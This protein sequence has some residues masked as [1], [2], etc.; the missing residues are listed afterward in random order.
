MNAVKFVRS[1]RFRLALTYTVV[2]FAIAAMALGGVY[3][4]LSRSL[5]ARPVTSGTAF[6]TFVDPATGEVITIG[7][8][9]HLRL[10][11][12]E[13]LVDEQTLADLRSI[14][15]WILLGLFPVSLLVGWFVADRTLRP[16]GRVVDVAGEITRTED[17]SRRIAMEGPDDE[18]KELADTFDA[19]LDK[20]EDGVHAR[21]RILQDISHELRNPLAVMATTLDVALDDPDAS[22]EDLRATAEVVRRTVDRTAESV[23]DL[24]A[25]AR[26]EIP[27]SRRTEVELGQMVR[28]IVAEHR[29]ALAAVGVSVAF[30]IEEPVRAVV[31]EEAVRR[32]FGNLVGNAVRLTKPGSTIE[33]GAGRSGG[34][35]WLSVDDHGPGIDPRDHEQVFRRYWS[36]DTSSLDGEA[37][38]GLGL[39]IAR[40]VAEAHGGVV[41]VASELG[42]GAEFTLWVPAVPGAAI[43]DVTDDGVHPRRAPL[44]DAT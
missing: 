4:A 25:L 24:V 6:T 17:L 38:G 21:R 35:A 43:G 13:E 3:L 30:Q 33:V 39:A 8:E 26:D 10:V 34:W 1:V 19:M 40:Q 32:A 11:T 2:V 28:E 36:R 14:S 9:V 23:D 31:D 41:T 20:I 29:G 37:R 27:E 16:I 5:H 15:L 42:A 12:V 44:R 22:A 18:L 7:R